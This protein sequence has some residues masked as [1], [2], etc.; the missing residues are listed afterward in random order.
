MDALREWFQDVVFGNGVIA[1]SV[2]A[3][4]AL[5]VLVARVFRPGRL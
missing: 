1:F 3:L 2:L 4:T 5:V